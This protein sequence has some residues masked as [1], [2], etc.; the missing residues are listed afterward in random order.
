MTS[1]PAASEFLEAKRL[2]EPCLP[3][4]ALSQVVSSF[5]GRLFSKMAHTNV[6]PEIKSEVDSCPS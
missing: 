2:L 6:L 1:K 4:T 3:R 5:N